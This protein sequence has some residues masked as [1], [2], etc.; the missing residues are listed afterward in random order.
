MI[1]QDDLVDFRVA[2]WRKLFKGVLR[3]HQVRKAWLFGSRARGDHSR[4]SDVDVIVELPKDQ[5]LFD[6]IDL[7][8]ALEQVAGKKVDLL[9]PAAIDE[10]FKKYSAL[11][12]N[13][14]KS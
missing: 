6:L 7:K 13:T 4:K 2:E 11:L 5:D 1:T 3:K 14:C 9:T 8:L 10:K 12:F